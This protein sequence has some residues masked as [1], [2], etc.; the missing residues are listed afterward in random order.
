MGKLSL[1]IRLFE[2][3]PVCGTFLCEVQDLVHVIIWSSMM[4]NNTNTIVLFLYCNHT[5]CLILGQES[6]D[7]LFNERGKL[8]PKVSGGG[9]QQFL[10][11][12]ALGPPSHIAWFF[13]RLVA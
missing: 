7:E 11:V 8:V 12:Q 3:V 4:L 10:K 1:T 5:L 9:K 13:R 2:F 6:C